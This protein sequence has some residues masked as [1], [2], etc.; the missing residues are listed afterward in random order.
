MKIDLYLDGRSVEINDDIDFVLNKQFTQLTDLTAIIVDYSKTVKIPMTPHNNEL[1]N[2]IYKIDHRVLLGINTVNYDPSQKI[3]MTMVY[4]GNLVME[5]YAVLSSVDLKDKMYEIN[6]YG[7]LGKLF[8]KMKELTLKNYI[9]EDNGFWSKI[10]MNKNSVKSSFENFNRDID[11]DSENWTDFFGFAPQLYGDQ[12]LLDTKSFECADGTILKFEDI[13]NERRSID[14]GDTYVDNGFDFNQYGELRS[15]MTRPYVYVSS[16]INLVK[17]Q[18]DSLSDYTLELDEEWFN[19]DNPYYKN[20]CYFPG[21]E[22]I[23]DKGEGNQG[24]VSW[25]NSEVTLTTYPINF[26]PNVSGTPELDGYTY[27]KDGTLVTITKTDGSS[28]DGGVKI[29]LS[30]IVLKQTLQGGIV[31][32]EKDNEF[33]YTNSNGY[34]PAHWIGIFDENEN[35]IYKLYLVDDEVYIC[36]ESSRIVEYEFEHSKKTGIWNKLKNNDL[37]HNIVPDTK[38]VTKS[39]S[40][41]GSTGTAELNQIFSFNNIVIFKSKFRMKFGCDLID[42]NT[43]EVVTENIT[44]SNTPKLKVLYKTKFMNSTYWIPWF[45]DTITYTTKFTPPSGLEVSSNTYRTG[46][47]WSIADILG[48]DFNPFEWFIEYCKMFRLHFDIDYMTKEITLTSQYFKNIYYKKMTVD[49]SKG[50]TIEPI[51]DNHSDVIFDYAENKSTKAT[52]Y[53]T[54]HNINYG[55]EKIK[56]GMEIVDETMSLTPN[57]D[58]AVFVPSIPNALNWPNLSAYW[59]N[60]IQT[61]PGISYGNI[62]QTKKIIDTRD[63]DKKCQYFPFYCFRVGNLNRGV[64]NY[65]YAIT[66]DTPTMK[67]EG[68]YT[69]LDARTKAASGMT[70]DWYT[71]GYALRMNTIPQFDNYIT[72]AVDVNS[73]LNPNNSPAVLPGSTTEEM[74]IVPTYVN[75]SVEVPTLK[76]YTY[77]HPLTG[78]TVTTTTNYDGVTNTTNDIT[79]SNITSTGTTQTFLFWSTFAVPMEVYNGEIPSNIQ[80]YS[81]YNRWKKYL[82]ELFNVNN[83]KVTCY[84]LMSYPEFINFRFNQ[85]FVIENNLFLVNKIVDF[86]PN[87]NEPTKVELFQITDVDNL[88]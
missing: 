64:G 49:Y 7:Q 80:S 66:D 21:N 83:K 28:P 52:K 17:S 78:E 5:G 87:S 33:V 62:I 18:M 15:Y 37:G 57:K 4:N 73:A 88:K 50:V 3:P 47:Y 48:N 74:E 12:D 23:I 68:N 65:F 77:K 32:A 38:S 72:M 40:H 9:K 53:K 2:Y 19:E 35:L 1:F 14:Y 79:P 56:T 51:I 58:L 25:V 27:S 26:L 31:Y 82:N 10:T 67:R 69:L 59:P 84:V 22:P 44:Y 6:L 55:D 24:N 85:L 8:S 34:F 71:L 45:T 86:N 46:T 41:S 16:L 43:G 13:I 61:V 29:D 11:W 63:K 60:T 42:A 75:M 81:L 76:K 70:S 20:L 54:L 30:S 36:R 39:Y